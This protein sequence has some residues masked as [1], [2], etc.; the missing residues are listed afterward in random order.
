MRGGLGKLHN[1]NMHNAAGRA[2]GLHRLRFCHLITARGQAEKVLLLSL[3]RRGRKARNFAAS[4]ATR[5]GSLGIPRK[6]INNHGKSTATKVVLATEPTA[7]L[8]LAVIEIEVFGNRR[9]RQITNPD[10]LSYDV[11]TCRERRAR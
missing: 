9:W 5:R 6:S 1:A 4:G 7:L 10:G 8:A 11:S 2:S 3:P